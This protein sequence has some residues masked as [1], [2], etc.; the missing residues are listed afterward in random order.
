MAMSV[1]MVSAFASDVEDP[2]VEEP[3][4]TAQT[5]FTKT[6]TENGENPAI[7]DET[8]KFTVTAA[9]TDKSEDTSY[10]NPGPSGLT[11]NDVDFTA[12]TTEADV[13]FTINETKFAGPG[14]YYFYV[15]E[16]DSAATHG[17]AYD[18]VTKKVVVQIF[19]DGT[20]PKLYVVNDTNGKGKDDGSFDN[21]YTARKLTVTK[22]VTGAQG[23]AA[24]TAK[25]KIYVTINGEDGKIYTNDKDSTQM[26][27]G[28]TY[29]FELASGESVN[30]YNLAD[31]DSYTVSEESY[32]SENYETTYKVNGGDATSTA[33]TNV[34][35]TET[36][37]VEVINNKDAPPVTGVIMNIAP[38]VLMVALAGGIAFFFLR[39]RHAE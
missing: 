16:D 15:T 9:A 10:N 32:A 29:T 4:A 14:T 5:K 18:T 2:P 13:T 11:V 31:G 37:T 8:F 17:M 21:V 7:K 28:Q 19:G 26:V 25:Y 23:N 1:M 22:T 30:I 27:T 38:Y 34:T 33:P 3:V 12:G 24:A 36:N 6:L 39:R 20:S 35:V